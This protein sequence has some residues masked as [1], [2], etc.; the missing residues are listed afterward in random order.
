MGLELRENV[1]QDGRFP[2]Q[3]PQGADLVMLMGAPCP[4]TKAS[5]T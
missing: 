3:G 2:L 4:T 5:R 1:G